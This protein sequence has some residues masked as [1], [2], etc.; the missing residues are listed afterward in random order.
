MIISMILS[1]TD[2][3]YSLYGIFDASTK[4]G[5]FPLIGKPNENSNCLP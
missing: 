2:D 5:K 1:L 3:Y 4:P